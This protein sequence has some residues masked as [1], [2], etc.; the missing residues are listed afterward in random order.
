MKR[1]SGGRGSVLSGAL[2]L[3]SWQTLA[4]QAG[5]IRA[6]VGGACALVDQA[7]RSKRRVR[8]L[9]VERAALVDQLGE[10]AAQ[11]RLPA[12]RK[13]RVKG[14]DMGDDIGRAVGRARIVECRAL[15]QLVDLS[16]ILEKTLGGI[17]ACGASTR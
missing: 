6:T 4:D 11:Q 15:M 5:E 8:K 9:L 16:H 12:E 13:L 1:G 14:P 17:L 10:I 2:S 3:H 7:L